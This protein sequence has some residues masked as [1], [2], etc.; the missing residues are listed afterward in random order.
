[1]S[2][3]DGGAVDQPGAGSIAS[4]AAEPFA[5]FLAFS[6]DGGTL[7]IWG[8]GGT[9]ALFDA[10]TGERRARLDGFAGQVWD[11]AFSPDGALL[12][13]AS[14]HGLWLGDPMTLQTYTTINISTQITDVQFV[15]RGA[16][17]A[18]IGDTITLLPLVSTPQQ[19][20][21][22][23][24]GFVDAEALAGAIGGQPIACRNL[25]RAESTPNGA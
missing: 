1:V 25:R 15:D 3:G 13:V 14:D 22:A 10:R 6:P 17:I 5:N 9:A 11:I 23:V 21:A 24:R 16:S 12:A 19:A 18:A 4:F 20:C 2:D 8:G 7:A